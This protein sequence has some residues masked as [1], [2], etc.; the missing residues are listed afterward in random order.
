MET[1]N[2]EEADTLLI[3]HAL[4]VIK[5]HEAGQQTGEPGVINVK[6]S[7]TDV[8]TYLVHLK[9]STQTAIKINMIAGT[10]K[11][12]NNLSIDKLMSWAGRKAWPYWVC[13]PLQ[14]VIGVVR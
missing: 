6:C 8:F 7:D 2:H 13:T 1:T 5:A 3:L 14:A 4:E 11:K 10:A 9:A 12:P